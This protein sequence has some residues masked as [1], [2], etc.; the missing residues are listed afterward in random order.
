MASLFLELL[1]AD[2]RLRGYSL[3]TEK[4]YLEWIRKYIYFI[5]KRH[6]S[7]AG[8]A[9]VK[10]FFTHLALNRNVALNAVV[11]LY[12]K[13]FNR[14]LGDFGF[15]LA[16]KQRHLPSVLSVREVG[17]ILAQ[18]SGR[19]RFIIELPYGSGRARGRDIEPAAQARFVVVASFDSFI[20]S[21]PPPPD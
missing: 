19:N 8:P 13:F 16:T 9:E 18:L 10:A 7:E 3:K 12:Q 4:S 14:E 15:K 1:I 20:S 21:A 17:L 6:P 5:G 11:F 2:I